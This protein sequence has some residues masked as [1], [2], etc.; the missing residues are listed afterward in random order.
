[1]K[2]PFEAVSKTVIW[3]PFST[4]KNSAFQFSAL[5]VHTA[6]FINKPSMKSHGLTTRSLDGSGDLA[7]YCKTCV[8]INKT[9]LV[10][11][12]DSRTVLEG[13]IHILWWSKP[14][15]ANEEIVG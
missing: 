3:F 1:M 13:L 9:N 8:G 10:Q 14:Q 6:L 15:R 5:R 4:P 11:M 12:T 7:T 2:Y